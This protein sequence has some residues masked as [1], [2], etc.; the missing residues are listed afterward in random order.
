MILGVKGVDGL[1]MLQLVGYN[2]ISLE[3]QVDIFNG[4]QFW[5]VFFIGIYIIEVYGVFGGNGM[6]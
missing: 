1:M 4:K 5:K 3:G 2:G 6:C